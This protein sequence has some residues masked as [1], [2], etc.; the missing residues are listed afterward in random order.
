MAGK[1]LRLIVVTPEKTVLDETVESLRFPLFDGEI[2]VLPG[3]LPMIGRLGCGNL[4]IDHTDG[5]VKTLFIDSGFVQVRDSV[6][7]LLTDRCLPADKLSKDAALQL[8][9]QARTRKSRTD[10]EVASRDRD[11]TRARKMLAALKKI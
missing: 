3:R 1:T 4:Y 11:L 9:E 2:G 10:H 8:Q 5:S 7:T 6:V